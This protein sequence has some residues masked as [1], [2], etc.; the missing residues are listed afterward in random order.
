MRARSRKFHIAGMALRAGITSAFCC[1]C[2][3]FGNLNPLT[4]DFVLD[5]MA[6][7]GIVWT[8]NWLC[9]RSSVR[10]FAGVVLSVILLFLSMEQFLT[11]VFRVIFAMVAVTATVYDIKRYVIVQ[12][13][14]SEHGY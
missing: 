6:V 9:V 14:R 3:I 7:G 5:F 12:D 11:G 4:L 8:I 2:A 13:S 1:A 10:G